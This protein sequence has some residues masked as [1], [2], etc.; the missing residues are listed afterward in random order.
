MDRRFL[1]EQLAAG[2]SL[3]QIGA[4]VG[5]HPSTVAYWLK[6]HGM[7]A[8]NHDKNAPKGTIDPGLFS[9]LV[10]LGLTRA[11]L[12][13]KLGISGSTVTYWLRK[14]RLH[15]KRGTLIV[16]SQRARE[17]GVRSL[18]RHCR[19]HGVGV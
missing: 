2:R 9:E 14:L 18:R 17:A 7:V 4:L 13:A 5:K 8:A 12:G 19:V 16:E 1:E 15:T 3:E 11:E 6:K 10:S